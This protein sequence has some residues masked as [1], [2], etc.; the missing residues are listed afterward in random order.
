MQEQ[1]TIVEQQQTDNNNN[2]RLDEVY[3]ENKL[4]IVRREKHNI[5]HRVK[6]NGPGIGSGRWVSVTSCRTSTWKTKFRDLWPTN[7]GKTLDQG[8]NNFGTFEHI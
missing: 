8:L 6:K 4:P 5:V 7:Y 3:L 2:L 1:P